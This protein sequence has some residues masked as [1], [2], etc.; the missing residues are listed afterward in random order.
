MS[1]T[2]SQSLA[3]QRLKDKGCDRIAENAEAQWLNCETYYIDDRVDM[4]GVKRLF[5]QGNADA[6][7]QR[8][9]Q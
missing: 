9:F 2:H 6:I 8:Q 1:L 3:I 5:K 4:R 7:H